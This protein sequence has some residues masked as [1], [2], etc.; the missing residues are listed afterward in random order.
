MGEKGP[1]IAD[2]D[3]SSLNMDRGTTF[4]AESCSRAIDTRLRPDSRRILIVE[5][6][7]ENS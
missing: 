5:N 2:D 3:L 4:I 7:H 1:Q 6:S